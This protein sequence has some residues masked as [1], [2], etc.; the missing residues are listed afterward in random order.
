M[1]CGRRAL[2]RTQEA[3][4]REMCCCQRAHTLHLCS[5]PPGMSVTS[6]GT[7]SVL[8]ACGTSQLHRGQDAQEASEVDGSA[9]W[10]S[11]LSYK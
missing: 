1:R 11:S 6:V 10:L 9:G 5:V 7:R 3:E 2:E 8:E 4:T